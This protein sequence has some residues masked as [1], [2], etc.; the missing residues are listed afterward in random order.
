MK[1]VSGVAWTW[2]LAALGAAA[3]LA[4]PVAAAE[5]TAGPD[6]KEVQAVV[7]KAVA[8]LKHRQNPDGSFSP[9]I[10]G[11]GI[12]ALVVAGLLRN[13][14]SPDDPV[15]AKTLDYL[16]KNVQKDGGIYEKHPGQ[17]HH[18]RGPDGLPGGQQ[19]ASTTRSSRTPPSSSRRCRTTRPGRQGPRSSAA[20]ATTAR[21][22]PTCPTPSTSSTRCSRPACPRTTRPSSGP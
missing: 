14:Y 21:A 12:S 9:E 22:G 20:S 19:R 3:M 1:T 18:Q 17:L 15:V 4:S 6:P 13:G 16:E 8:Y 11:P 7:E 2:A 10:A 5:P